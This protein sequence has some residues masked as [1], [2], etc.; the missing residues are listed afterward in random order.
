MRES[1]S[2]GTEINWSGFFD[3]PTEYCRNGGMAFADVISSATCEE[4]R[5]GGQITSLLTPMLTPSEV[6]H[7]QGKD[8]GDNDSR[9]FG[10]SNGLICLRVL[11]ERRCDV[12]CGEECDA[13]IDPRGERAVAA[14]ERRL[15]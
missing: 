8:L 10:V 15:S 6:A 3:A 12:E 13:S 5:A 1:T 2:L 11:D 4:V 7:L 9:L 14:V